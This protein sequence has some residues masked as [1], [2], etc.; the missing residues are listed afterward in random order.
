MT[1]Y[2]ALPP[3]DPA[4][5]AIYWLTLF[6]SGEAG[7]E[8]QKAFDRWLAEASAHRAAWANA[9]LLWQDVMSLSDADIPEITVIPAQ[10]VTPIRP[11]RTMLF[12][13]ALS[14]AACVLLSAVLWLHELA[15]YL[16]DYRTGTGNH[17]KITLADG[18]SIQ[19]NTD[20]AISVD[21][22]ESSRRLTLHG[23][24]AWFTVASD[25]DRPF[26]VATEYGTVRALGTAFDVKNTEDSVTVTVYQHAVRVQLANGEKVERLPE[27]AALRFDQTI[28]GLN[29]PADLTA[30]AAWHEQRMVLRIAAKRTHAVLCFREQTP[31][32]QRLGRQARIL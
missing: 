8:Q 13:P 26:E 31:I 21:Y 1:D 29:N 23:G 19:L 16:A 20:T 7:D 10:K 12:H 3:G 24:E 28:L 30:T 27:G 32:C 15:Y 25:P 14:L 5:Q 6:T 2:P 4:E 9:Q 17:Q 11:R 18:S 22:S